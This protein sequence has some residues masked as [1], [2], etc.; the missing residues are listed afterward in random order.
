MCNCE[1]RESWIDLC[2][3]DECGDTTMKYAKATKFYE[4][5][6]YCRH[7]REEHG[8]RYASWDDA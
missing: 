4:G 6:E 7:L 5:D 1:K 8:H 3:E 2:W